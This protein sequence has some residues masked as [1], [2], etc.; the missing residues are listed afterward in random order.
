M[1]EMCYNNA[2]G[3]VITFRTNRCSLYTHF[4]CKIYVNLPTQAK[5]A[6][7]LRPRAVRES[8]V[9]QGRVEQ[10]SGL[11]KYFS[12]SLSLH[13]P[14][15]ANPLFSRLCEAL[16]PR[17]GSCRVYTVKQNGIE[18]YSPAI[19]NLPYP[20]LSGILLYTFLHFFYCQK[21]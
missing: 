8:G 15:S 13:T 3:C 21:L 7:D 20:T 17:F 12:I 18:R 6:R 1:A 11:Q 14:T 9:G 5:T 10:V 2:P 16:P 19:P 4:T